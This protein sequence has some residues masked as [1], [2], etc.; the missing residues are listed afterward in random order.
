MQLNNLKTGE[1]I[2]NRREELGIKRSTLAKKLGVA[3]TTVIRWENGEIQTVKAS[4]ISSLAEILLVPVGYLLGMQD[5]VDSV[6]LARAKKKYIDRANNLTL[7][8]LNTANSMLDLM[9]NN[10]K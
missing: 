6:E 2:R 5:N 9:F 3:K 10:K 8:Q 4:L 7:D 1:R